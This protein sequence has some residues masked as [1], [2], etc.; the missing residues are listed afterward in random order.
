M[1]LTQKIRTMTLLCAQI[2]KP[3]NEGHEKSLLAFLMSLKEFSL[4]S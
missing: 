2:K 3:S 4:T 1:D